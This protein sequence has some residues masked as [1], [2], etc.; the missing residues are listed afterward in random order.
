MRPG[1]LWYRLLEGVL[2][3]IVLLAWIL[4][5]QLRNLRYILFVS[6][7]LIFFFL[8]FLTA[9]VATLRTRHDSNPLCSVLLDG[10]DGLW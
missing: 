2:I 6:G 7:I 4:S 1:P 5:E 9:A 10:K 3:V 8:R